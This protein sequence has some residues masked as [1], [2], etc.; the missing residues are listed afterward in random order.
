MASEIFC[1]GCYAGLCERLTSPGFQYT[2][3]YDWRKVYEKGKAFSGRGIGF[4]NGSQYDWLW[5]YGEGF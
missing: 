5:K 2:K 1:K 3:L 4:C